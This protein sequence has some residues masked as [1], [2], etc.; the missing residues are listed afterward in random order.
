MDDLA[1]FLTSGERQQVVLHLLNSLRADDGDEVDGIK[2][3]EGEAIGQSVSLSVFLSCRSTGRGVLSV[4]R[5]CYVFPWE[6]RGPAW[7]VGSYSISQSAG[8]TSQNIIFQTL[9]QIGRYAPLCIR[10]CTFQTA[11]KAISVLRTLLSD[12]Q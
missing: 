5:F 2:F 8:R 7:A 10:V 11:K 4:A 1:N 3:R 12:T 6:L 9:Q